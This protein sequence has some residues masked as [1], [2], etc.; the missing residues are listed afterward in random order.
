MTKII[1]RKIVAKEEILVSGCKRPSWWNNSSELIFVV[2]VRRIKFLLVIIPFLFSTLIFYGSFENVSRAIRIFF[3]SI[4]ILIIAKTS[5][6][7]W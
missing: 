5:L 2:L 7:E 1:A 3:K 4:L 6:D